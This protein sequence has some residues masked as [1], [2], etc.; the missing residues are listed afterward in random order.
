[1]STVKMT[2]TIPVSADQIW[3]VIG[4]F[5]ALPD[6]HP[7]VVRSDLEEGGAI[8]RLTL[9]GGGEIVERLEKSDDQGQTYTYSII[10]SPLPVSGYTATIKVT[11]EGG[12]VST[13][14]WSSSFKPSGA[15]ENDAIKAIESIYQAGFDNL[16]QM[17]GG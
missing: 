13:V 16:K 17:F 7:G 6:W 11:E 4:Q 12:G 8:R 15:P 1:M 10:E 2:T 5:N 9:T 3:N 14:E